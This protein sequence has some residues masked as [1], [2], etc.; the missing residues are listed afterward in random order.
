MAFVGF[1]TRGKNP[2]GKRQALLCD[3]SPLVEK[4]NDSCSLKGAKNPIVDTIDDWSRFFVGCLTRNWRVYGEYIWYILRA[5]IQRIERPSQVA[6]QRGP[7]EVLE[8][9]LEGV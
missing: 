8:W 6:F 3:F 2:V 5:L 1:F 9:S 7:L 4:R